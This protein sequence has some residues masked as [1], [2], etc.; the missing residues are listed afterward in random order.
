MMA[1]TAAWAA[2][3]QCSTHSCWFWIKAHDGATTRPALSHAEV[4]IGHMLQNNLCLGP[5]RATEAIAL[6]LDV[7][8]ANCSLLVMTTVLGRSLT[9]RPLDKPQSLGQNPLGNTGS[10]HW[11]HSVAGKAARPRR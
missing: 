4:P 10:S 7:H 11:Q 5:W 8:A 6:F 3:I 9:D 1:E 2:S